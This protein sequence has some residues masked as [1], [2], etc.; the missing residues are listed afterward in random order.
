MQFISQYSPEDIVTAQIEGSSGALWRISPPSRAQMKRELYNGTADI[1]LRFTWNFQR[2]G[3]GWGRTLAAGPGWGVARRGSRCVLARRDLAKGGTVEYT[4]EK[5][6]LDLAAN[7][8]ERRQLASL[9]EGTSD[10]SV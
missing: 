6:T 10:Q 4:N 9:L 2:C 3:P 1:T 8:S 5:H 7:S